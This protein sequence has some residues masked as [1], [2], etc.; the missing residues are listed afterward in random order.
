MRVHCPY[1][2]YRVIQVRKLGW[3]PTSVPSARKLFYVPEDPKTPS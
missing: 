3:S 1:C 2:E